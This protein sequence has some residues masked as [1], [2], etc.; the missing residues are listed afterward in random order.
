MLIAGAVIV[1][2]VQLD[3]AFARKHVDERR[4][5]GIYRTGGVRIGRLIVDRRCDLSRIYR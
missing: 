2:D 1:D 3:A 4:D 5:A